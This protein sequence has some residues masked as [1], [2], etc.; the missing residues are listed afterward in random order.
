MKAGDVPGTIRHDASRIFGGAAVEA[1]LGLRW[2]VVQG[3]RSSHLVIFPGGPVDYGPLCGRSWSATFRGAP[4][5]VT[6]HLLRHAEAEV[7]RSCG[8][9]WVRIHAGGWRILESR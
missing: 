6:E 1:P 9:V 3:S 5:E 2:L 7:C 4:R 8:S